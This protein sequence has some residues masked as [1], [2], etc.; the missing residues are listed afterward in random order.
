MRPPSHAG[1]LM[2]PLCPS[3]ARSLLLCA[4][5]PKDPT[6]VAATLAEEFGGCTLPEPDQPSTHWEFA[7]FGSVRRQFMASQQDFANF[8]ELVLP[9]L[10]RVGARG[11]MLWR[12]AD[13]AQDLY[14][15]GSEETTHREA[16]D[17][18]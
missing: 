4:G 3:S 8:L 11:A 18:S 5:P 9:L 7:T 10:V 2:R 1:P 17:C 15:V 16:K 13:Y 6:L 12:F 14:G